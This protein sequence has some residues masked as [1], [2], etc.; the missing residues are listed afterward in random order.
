[1]GTVWGLFG[2]FLGAFVLT[3]QRGPTCVRARS[4]SLMKD[5]SRTGSTTSNANSKGKSEKK[6]QDEVKRYE[7][8]SLEIA[9][10]FGTSVK[11]LRF[12][13]A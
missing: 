13:G 9:E 7:T 11:H 3:V 1:M 12:K 10:Q 4:P 6:L 2:F 5:L 8:F